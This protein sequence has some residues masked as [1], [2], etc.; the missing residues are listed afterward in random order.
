MDQR[1]R[2]RITAGMVGSRRR[3]RARARSSSSS[4]RN[5]ER[6][7]SHKDL[8]SAD[9]R[10]ENRHRPP[11][12]GAQ[13]GANEDAIV[14]RRLAGKED[15]LAVLGDCPVSMDDVLPRR[16]EVPRRQKL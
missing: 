1:R 13:F 10:E 3:S 11:D 15:W 6:A 8:G 4:R 16:R 9:S 7:K 14:F 12:F 5:Q 2:E